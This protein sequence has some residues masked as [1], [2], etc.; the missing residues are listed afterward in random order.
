M[1]RTTLR[2]KFVASFMVMCMIICSALPVFAFESHGRIVYN[3]ATSGDQII[4]NSDEIIE[5]LQ[6]LAPSS[7]SSYTPG[8]SYGKDVYIMYNGHLY[9]SLIDNNTTTPGSDPAKWELI[10]T[11]EQQWEAMKTIDANI[12]SI[13]TDVTSIKATVEDTNTKVSALDFSSVS[14]KIDQL[15]AA[16]VGT[17]PSGGTVA[18]LKTMIERIYSKEVGTTGN[19][20]IR[21]GSIA[22]VY[23]NDETNPTEFVVCDAE[24]DENGNATKLYMLGANKA[25]N[26]SIGEKKS[27]YLTYDQ[28]NNPTTMATLNSNGQLDKTWTWKATFNNT[29]YKSG[30]DG[31]SVACIPDRTF[32]TQHC[33]NTVRNQTYWVRDSWKNCVVYGEDITT[34]AGAKDVCGYDFVTNSSYYTS[35]FVPTC[36]PGF[37]SGVFCI[38]STGSGRFAARGVC[39]AALIPCIEVNL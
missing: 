28:V 3:D 5:A 8:T 10:P 9:K 34:A 38:D 21:V 13:A 24:Y 26:W 22:R 20:D 32:I 27:S 29:E 25:D 16:L 23:L 6:A 2:T 14:T 33:N 4:V 37:V 19:V 39:R 35:Y 36:S 18:D 7:S 1:K 17:V 11:I 31:N 15:S 30:Y 12:N